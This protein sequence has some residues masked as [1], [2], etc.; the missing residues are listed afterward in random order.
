MFDEAVVTL[1][2]GEIFGV[3]LLKKLLGYFPFRKSAI[4]PQRLVLCLELL[5]QFFGRLD[6]G[7][8]SGCSRV[9]KERSRL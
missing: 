4:E 9:G 8:K 7:G 5:T 2:K 1:P 3:D 6:P